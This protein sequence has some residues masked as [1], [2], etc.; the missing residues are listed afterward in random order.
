MSKETVAAE[1]KNKLPAVD[2]AG[3]V[4]PLAAAFFGLYMTL[5]PVRRMLTA[6]F[7]AR[8]KVTAEKAS[9]A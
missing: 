3:A 1:N 8:G 2:L 9:V 6:A 5:L 7:V 4:L